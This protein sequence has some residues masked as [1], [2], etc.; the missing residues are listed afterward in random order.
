[1]ST[2]LSSLVDNLSE[3]YKKECKSCKEKKIMSECKFI[4]LKNNELYFKYKECNNESYKSINGLK[5][6]FLNT[7][8]FCMKMLINLF[9]Y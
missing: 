9:C 2:S 6:N 4:D 8:R 7:Y 1:M 5:E 3:I